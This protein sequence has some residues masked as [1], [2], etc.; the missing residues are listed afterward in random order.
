MFNH[1]IALLQY[2]P[3]TKQCDTKYLFRAIFGI[4]YANKQRYGK[5]NSQSGK[6]HSLWDDY[7]GWLHCS[8]CLHLRSRI[9]DGALIPDEERGGAGAACLGA[10]LVGVPDLLANWAPTAL[11]KKPPP[12]EAGLEEDEGLEVGLG[13]AAFVGVS[14]LFANCA[15]TALS[16]KPPPEEAGLEE[17][18]GLEE[19]GLGEEALVG[20]SDFFAN[21]APTALSKKPG[22]EGL[23][24]EGLLE[25]EGLE[26]G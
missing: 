17:D 6:Q 16:K 21:W 1:K 4:Y 3:R 10:S 15:P 14:D 20:V 5:M 9:T 2:N 26:E 25:E 8:W 24:E 23:L 11:S 18:E 12:E 19:E 13:E 7:L 22:E